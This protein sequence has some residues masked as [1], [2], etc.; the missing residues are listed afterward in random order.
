MKHAEIYTVT[1]SNYPEKY[2]EIE[3][4]EDRKICLVE[5]KYTREELDQFKAEAPKWIV[6]RMGSHCFLADSD[7]GEDADGYYCGYFDP[8]PEKAVFENGKFVGLYICPDSFNYSG[9]GRYNFSVDRWGYPGRNPFEYTRW[10]EDTHV[11]LFAEPKTCDWKDWDLL[12]RDPE[13][14]YK[15]YLDF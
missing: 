5:K 1:D 6:R 7:S 8:E 11:F 14:E 3:M 4:S 15:S 2:I 13:K 9:N 10:G 12:V